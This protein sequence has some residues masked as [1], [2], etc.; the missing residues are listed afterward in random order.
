MSRLLY[1]GAGLLLLAALGGGYWYYTSSS[2]AA[3]TFKTEPATKGDLVATVAATGTLEPEE[4]IDVGAQVAGQINEFGKGAD[5]KIIDYKSPVDAGTVLA[6]IDDAL[7]KA[8]VDQ[9]RAVKDSAERQVEQ[10]KAK[11]EQAIAGV[12]QARANTLRAEADLIQSKAKADQTDKDWVRIQ[13][14]KAGNSIS[15]QEYDAAKSAYDANRA[16]VQVSDAALTQTRAAEVN[17]KALVSDAKAAVGVAEAAVATASAQLR[18]EEVNL[19]YCT[20]TSSVKGTIIDRRVTMGQTVQSSFNTP[21]LFLIAK[22][23][24]R[25]TVWASVNE[26]DIG[27]IHDGQPVKFTVDAFPGQT[28]KGNVSRIRLNATNTQNVVVYTVEVTT[29]NQDL[30]LFPYMTANLAFEIDRRNDAVLIP[31]AALRYKPAAN[32][33]KAG[34]EGNGETKGEGPKSEGSK[35]EGSKEKGK[36]KD[37]RRGTVYVE[38]NGGLRAINVV[39]GLTDGTNTEVVSGDVQSGMALVVGEVK[40]ASTSEAGNAFAPPRPGGGPGGGGKKQ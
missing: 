13:N 30:K 34:A 33:V 6:R 37:Q 5:G 26:A 35:G 28:F 38:E 16:L 12:D 14:L 17:A 19:G 27:Q 1:I 20:I 15:D 31:N 29:E 7:Y 10:N 36:G 9:A 8:R 23:L 2:R 21:S 32:L 18:Q 25:M 11:L 4:V 40:A 3:V 22:D 24:T 39:L